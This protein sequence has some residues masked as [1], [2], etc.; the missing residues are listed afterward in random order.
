MCPCCCL[1]SLVPAKKDAPAYQYRFETQQWNPRQTAIVVCDFWD[2]H[3]CHNAVRRMKEIGPRLNRVIE[4]ARRQGVTII[5]SPS[6]CMES[7][8]DH[9]AR[10]RAI[11]APASP[12]PVDISSWCSRIPT[13]EAAT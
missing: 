1:R 13:E 2:Y 10:Q 11:Q 5:H 4:T 7:Y 8:R 3:H 9:P 6:D 12:S